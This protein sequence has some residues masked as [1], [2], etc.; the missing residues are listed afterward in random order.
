MFN[1]NEKVFS[2]DNLRKRLVPTG[3]EGFD[4]VLGG[5]FPKNSLIV[6]VGCPGS[7][8]TIFSAQFLYRGCVEYDDNGVYVS[9][10]ESKDAFYENM[11]SFGY[12]F[13]KLEDSGKFRFLDLL[14]VKEGGIPE[15]IELILREVTELGAKRLVVDPFSALAQAFKEP[16]EVRV[17]LHTVLSKVCRLQGCT[18]LIIVENS[19]MNDKDKV[20]FGVEGFVAD[21]IIHMGRSSL[22]GR[23][24]REITLFKMRGTPLPETRLVFT[25][26]D[27]FKAFPPFKAKPVDKPCRFK[28]QPDT[29]QFFSSGIPSLDEMLGGGYP[30]GSPVLIEI[31]EHVSTLQ[32]HLIAV[33]TA[34][35]FATQG[36]G[37]IIIPSAGVDHNLI[38]KR[39][40]EGGLTLDEINSLLRVGIKEDYPGIK[41]EPYLVAFKG[42][43]ISEDYKR[44]MEIE[45]EL[46]ERTGQ[47]VLRI[48]GVDMLTDVY[49]IK[50]TISIL[51]MDATWIKENGGLGII[52]LKPGYPQLAKTLGAIADIH[53]KITREHGTII[54]CGVKPRTCF[55]ALEMDT[56]KGYAM[57]KLTPII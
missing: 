53:L 11:R 6:L 12:D 7:G 2:D 18:T 40:E 20:V 30:R 42:E 34:W 8:K 13:R 27:G 33:P 17:F 37:I 38:K 51:K 10:A 1:E 47:P 26:K 41:Q 49:G 21:G 9:F 16:H 29:D 36:R 5:G 24:L 45:R 48:T 43:N 57:P 50:E 52:L 22:M 32:Y 28:P 15:V 25:L 35:N 23:P 14:T 54:V 55:Y 19:C 44:Y 39:A 4:A 31:S 56:S 3:V 46:V